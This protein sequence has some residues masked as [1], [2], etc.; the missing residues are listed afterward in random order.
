MKEQIERLQALIAVLQA[1]LMA[2]LASQQ[3]PE[4]PEGAIDWDAVDYG[5]DG[6][7]VGERGGFYVEGIGA[8]RTEVAGSDS[9]HRDAV[10]NH[11]Y[12][13]AEYLIP[14]GIERL[15]LLRHDHPELYVDYVQNIVLGRLIIPGGGGSARKIDRNL[16]F[17]TALD[18]EQIG[19]GHVG[20]L[21]GVYRD[22]SAKD[23]T[24][25]VAKLRAWAL[26]ALKR[27]LPEPDEPGGWP[28]LAPG[29]GRVDPIRYIVR[30]GVRGF[31]TGRTMHEIFGASNQ[32]WLGIGPG[33]YVE[34]EFDRETKARRFHLDGYPTTSSHIRHNGE[35]VRVSDRSGARFGPFDVGDR[36]RIEPTGK[37][38]GWLLVSLQ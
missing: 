19:S 14:L 25:L 1:E 16:T 3:E 26:D 28:D 18:F 36:L 9:P 37:A 21:V 7:A 11:P 22:E 27:G 32:R 5:P 6:L 10:L 15:A 17:R 2:L 4:T 35:T 38:A 31:R 12:L 13:N 29:T 34:I 23:A 20:T 30:R 33:Q 24:D 8:L